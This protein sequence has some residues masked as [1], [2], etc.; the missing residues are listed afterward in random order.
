MISVR[1]RGLLRTAHK[2]LGLAAALFLL[3]Q[4]AT[5]V[6]LTFKDEIGWR[7]DS[8]IRSD[9][10]AGV[11]ISP[12]LALER[13]R[14]A[15]KRLYFPK[16]ERGVFLVKCANRG[17]AT[18]DQWSGRV[19]AAGPAWRFPF[20]FADEWHLDWRIA[21]PGSAIVGILG[22]CLLTLAVSGFFVWWPGKRYVV[23]A[24]RPVWRGGVRTRLRMLHRLVGPVV[25]TF[26]VFFITAGVVTAWRP[27]I[28]PL[29]GRVLPLEEAPA[30][31]QVTQPALNSLMPLAEVERLALAALPGTTVRDMRNQDGRF[32]LIQLI[33]NPAFETR[34]RAADHVWV[35]RRSGH[36]LGTRRTAHE[37]AGTRLLG[38]VLPIHTGQVFGVAGRILMLLVGLAVLTLAL[39]GTIA[40]LR[41]SR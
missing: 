27:W 29:V 5:G 24:M 7:I 32:E 37:P 18:V 10:S 41:R 38:W 6:M 3:M 36:L 16:H 26:I 39:S 14:C 30:K 19:I 2:W 34:P 31:P 12:D 33:M 15:P 20:E 22:L 9:A 21:R 1:S 4:A 23:R 17:I 11:R 40:A 25:L 8:A 35:D 13:A 28:E